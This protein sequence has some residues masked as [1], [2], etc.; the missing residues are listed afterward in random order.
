MRERVQSIFPHNETSRRCWHT[1]GGSMQ[2]GWRCGTNTD[3]NNSAARE[4][5]IYQ[6]D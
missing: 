5:I 2:G 1:G 6:G 3:L 4:R